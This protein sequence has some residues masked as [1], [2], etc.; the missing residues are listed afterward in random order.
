ME[1]GWSTEWV[2]SRPASLRKGRK[3]RTEEGREGQKEE[4]REREKEEGKEGARKQQYAY[5]ATSP[6][7]KNESSK[8]SA[9]HPP[10]PLHGSL[11]SNSG[12]QV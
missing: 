11:G 6:E 12:H 5:H 1:P 7:R 9:T 2:P 8:E 4:G 3:G 10:V